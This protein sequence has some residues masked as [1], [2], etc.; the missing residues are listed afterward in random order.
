VP[1]LFVRRQQALKTYL[2][3]P[4]TQ[5]SLTATVKSHS[6][7]NWVSFLTPCLMGKQPSTACSSPTPTTLAESV[8]LISTLMGSLTWSLQRPFWETW[9]CTST[10]LT[11][12]LRLR[13]SVSLR[14]SWTQSPTLKLEPSPRSQSLESTSPAP[15]PKLTSSSSSREPSDLWA[16][17]RTITRS[18]SKQLLL[19]S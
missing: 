9:L 16:K 17:T 14:S 5:I 6:F 2:R 19:Q 7:K 8:L 18:L 10:W 13:R 12:P 1:K 11:Q 4:S 15:T 3:S